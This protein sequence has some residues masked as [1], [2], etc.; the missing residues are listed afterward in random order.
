MSIR[1]FWH[2]EIAYL[3][4]MVT[5]GKLHIYV[6]DYICW[7]FRKHNYCYTLNIGYTELNWERQP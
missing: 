7:S 2:R 6:Y 3:L 1:V 4:A 5:V